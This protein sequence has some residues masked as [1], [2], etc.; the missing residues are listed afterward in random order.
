MNENY[1]LYITFFTCKS[2][3]RYYDIYNIH[4]S[5]SI[6]LDALVIYIYNLNR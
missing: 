5:F 1:N 2:E 3:T 6:K 4:K